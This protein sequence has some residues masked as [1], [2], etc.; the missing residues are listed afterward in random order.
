MYTCMWA[1]QVGLVAHG[2]GPVHILIHK[3]TTCCRGHLH[4]S[5]V[6]IGLAGIPPQSVGF[7]AHMCMFM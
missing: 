3:I 6:K 5:N 2:D 7:A 1:H 4:I